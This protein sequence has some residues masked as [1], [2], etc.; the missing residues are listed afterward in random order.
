M[1]LCAHPP[2]PPPPCGQE[3]GTGGAAAPRLLAGA[4]NSDSK[5]PQLA[6]WGTEPWAPWPSGGHVGFVLLWRAKKKQ[7]SKNLAC[8]GLPTPTPSP[9]SHPHAPLA[10]IR[11]AVTSCDGHSEPTSGAGHPCRHQVNALCLGGVICRCCDGGRRRPRP[12]HPA[13]PSSGHR[14]QVQRGPPPRDITHIHQ[15]W[16][17]TCTWRC[18]WACPGCGPRPES[19]GAR[20]TPGEADFCWG[21][22]GCTSGGGRP[23]PTPRPRVWRV[24]R[25]HCLRA[26][27]WRGGWGAPRAGCSHP[28]EHQ[29]E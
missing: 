10:A 24:H 14:A 6:V 11:P 4:L 19:F 29:R 9:P 12:W 25:R 18:R 8:R 5:L 26:R 2:P 7:Q 13:P 20:P 27:A 3:A 21:P 23:H 17:R 16:R 28:P 22:T 15:A 1:K